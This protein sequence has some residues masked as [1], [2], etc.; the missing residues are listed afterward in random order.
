MYMKEE[1]KNLLNRLLWSIMKDSQAGIYNA[2]NDEDVD[3]AQYQF[4]YGLY[5]LTELKH[6]N[7]GEKVDFEN[8][9][10]ALESAIPNE[11]NLKDRIKVMLDYG[12]S[13]EKDNL[14]DFTKDELENGIV[15]ETYELY[16]PSDELIDELVELFNK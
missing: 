1:I 5:A 6:L 12:F 8:I 16:H 3:E 14:I 11:D 2:F 9:S 4:D 10:M 7:N 15:K 13:K